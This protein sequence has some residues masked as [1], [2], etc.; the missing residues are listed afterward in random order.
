MVRQHDPAGADAD[1]FSFCPAT[2]PITTEVAA[3]AM[4]G[5]VVMFGQPVA[6]IAPLLR[7]LREIERVAESQRGVAAF[8]DGRK[9]ENGEPRHAA[10]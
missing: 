6:M 1:A 4:P 5:E 8:D 2:W 10:M 7:V 9:I 3:L